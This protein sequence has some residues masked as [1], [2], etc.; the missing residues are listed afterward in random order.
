MKKAYH[1]L[2]VM[3]LVIT[4][5]YSCKKDDVTE[6]E[7]GLPASEYFGSGITINAIGRVLDENGQ[8]ISGANVKSGNKSTTTDNMGVFALSA[9]SA[10][11]KL[12]TV[13]VEKTGFYK[14]IRSFIPKQE[15]NELSIT[16]LAKSITGSF[17]SIDGG[18]VSASGVSVTIDPNSIQLNNVPYN[19]VVNVS[20]KHINPE[21]PNFRSEM[22]GSLVGVDSANSYGLVSYGMMA[23]ELTSNSGQKLQIANGKTAEIRLV[24]PASLMANAPSTIPLWSLDE[25]LGV[26]K[27]ESTAT[28][29]NNVYIGN[30]SHF[31]FWNADY[32]FDY[33]NLTGKFFD[34]QS[35]LPIAGLVVTI[36]DLSSQS[37][38]I[39][40]TNSAG[41]VRGFVPKNKNLKLT[42]SKYCSGNKVDLY[43]SIIGPFSSD[44]N[45]DSVFVNTSQL[46]YTNISGQITDCNNNLLAASYV[47]I[48]GNEIVYSNNGF[49]STIVCENSVVLSAGIPLQTSST[50]L[51]N[52]NGTPQVANFQVCLQF[53]TGTMNDFDGNFYKTV[54]I[55]NQTWMAENLRTT[56]YKLGGYIATGLNNYYWNTATTPAYTSWDNDTAGDYVYGKLYNWYAVTDPAGLCPVGWRVPNDS[57]WVEL[58]DAL[59]GQ[60]VA[61]GYLKETGYSHWDFPNTGSNNLTGFNALP[62][63]TRIVAGTYSGRRT[64]GLWW[65]STDAGMSGSYGSAVNMRF[66]NSESNIS[67]WDRRYGMSVRCIKN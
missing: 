41:R 66:D 19:G 22:P 58:I 24:V 48:N 3:L 14:G 10:F 46:V 2:I 27:K 33:I 28:L 1:R 50:Q 44:V 59:G 49:Y 13:T 37:S 43:T 6:I 61:G 45:L 23:V 34:S 31:S 57:D 39:D 4:T 21:R 47:T 15:N 17:N 56:H 9:I 65:S 64:T 53:N 62:A 35:S 63:G 30:V 20:I 36:T 60:T 67:S 40:I 7:S 32:P 55:G 51:L 54:T 8:P 52:L 18:T 42:A 16:L 26:W 25:T 5:F 11:D 38:G 29:I 12:G